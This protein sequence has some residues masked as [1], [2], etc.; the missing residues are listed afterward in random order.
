MT[1]CLPAPLPGMTLFEKAINAFDAENARDPRLEEVEGEMVPREL[2]YARRMSARL[3]SF[4]PGASEPL[5]LAARCQHIRR[6]DI[7][8]EAHPAGR[9][10]YRGWRSALAQHHAGIAAGLLSAVGYREE[11]IARVRDLVQ[12]RRLKKDEEVQ[13]LEDVACLVFLEH[14]FAQF[15]RDHEDEKLVEIVRKTWLKMSPRGREAAGMLAFSSRLEEIV[16]RATS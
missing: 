6:W 8:R 5:R 14:Y 15:A 9:S 7:P 11:V 4:A 13:T 12:K 1:G 16:A 2:L 3:A 10:G